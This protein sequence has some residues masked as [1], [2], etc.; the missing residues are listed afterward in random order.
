MKRPRVVDPEKRQ[1]AAFSCD[2]CKTRK[3]KCVRIVPEG[4]HQL[5]DK[6]HPCTLCTK[7]GEQC[8]T[9]V[10]RRRR[11][12]GSFENLGIHYQTV[13]SLVQGLYPDFDINDVGQL[14]KL[15]TEL[16]INMATSENAMEME[17][18]ILKPFT[19]KRSDTVSTN[20]SV[21]LPLMSDS[22][23][24]RDT[25]VYD[26][27]GGSH[28]VGSSGTPLLFTLLCNLLLKRS[29]IPNLSF[30]NKI[31]LFQNNVR[32]P[33]YKN[34]C[35]SLLNDPRFPIFPLVPSRQIADHFVALFF[36]KV[37]PFYFIFEQD[38]FIRMHNTFWEQLLN[39]D[40]RRK[41]LPNTI[42]GCIYLVWLIA[43]RLTDSLPFDSSKIDELL[44]LFLTDASLGAS[45]SS[46]QFLYLYATYL[47][48]EKNR[49][50][51]WNLIGLAIRQAMSLGFHRK[52]DHSKQLLNSSQL[53]WSLYQIELSMCANF[54]RQCNINE[55]EIDIDYPDLSHMSL[56]AEFKEYYS[57]T[58]KLSRFLNRIIKERKITYSQQPLSLINIERTLAMKNQLQK[59]HQEL[60]IKPT[61]QIS[62]IYDFKLT[63]LYSHYMA[64]LT[65]PFLIHITTTNY[66]I[67]E[68]ETLLSIVQVGLKSAITISKVMNL[69]QDFHN[70][71]ISND[72]M[73]GYNSALSLSLFWIYL[74]NSSNDTWDLSFELENEWIRLDKSSTL[75]YIT[76]ISQ[77]MQNYKLDPTSKRIAEVIKGL[78]KDLRLAESQP[79]LGFDILNFETTDQLVYDSL[80][81]NND[82][83]LDPW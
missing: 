2:R 49:D 31:T 16:G 28:Y 10:P 66:N 70:G 71:A 32:K 18:K 53:F 41:E 14:I 30:D 68:D 46:I 58:L 47:H 55:D 78:T 9:S 45:T 4:E 1:R 83:Y 22:S 54:G 56:T 29:L 57:S 21:Q 8:V 37:H 12:Y 5:E 23:P 20:S 82:I 79:D 64:A 61:S 6:T 40:D 25:V 42:V 26:S 52:M 59:M 74:C 69:T 50:A 51:S 39:G 76:M 81:L 38:Q 33:N 11:V 19:P 60:N 44:Q 63:L 72:C 73:I 43:S 34:I 77:F 62:S 67:R 3:T 35:V 75:E 7:A 65:L 17:S 48:S 36:Q 15:G 13:V 24:V 80:F 27:K